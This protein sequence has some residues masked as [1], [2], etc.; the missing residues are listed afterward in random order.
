MSQIQLLSLDF[1]GTLVRHW[2]SPPYPDELV[3]MLNQLRRSGVLLAIN[4]GRTVRL[5]EEALQVTGFPV[6]PDFALTSEREVF[7]WNG[8]T[9]EDYGGWNSRCREEHDTLFAECESLLSEIEQYL[10]STTAARLHYDE[11]RFS[12]IVSNTSAE[13]DEICRFIETKRLDFPDFAYQRNSVYLRF[14]HLAYHKGTAL[15]EL[16]RLVG[17]S[18]EST[19][20]AGDNFNDLPMLN[21][22]FAHFLACPSNA[23]E[24]VKTV[25]KNQGGF[26]ASQESGFGICEALRHFF[27]NLV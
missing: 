10:E 7:R 26:V 11:N 27:P 5:V 15:A 9:W 23:L 12:G 3:Q 13:M 24:D 14:C 21:L 20:A 6:R 16:Q 4:T 25:V 2:A 19:F 1:D 8:S 17:L 22:S 18:S